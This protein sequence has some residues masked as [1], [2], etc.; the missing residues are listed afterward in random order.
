MALLHEDAEN[1]VFLEELGIGRDGSAGCINTP[2][3]PS[4]GQGGRQLG[5]YNYSGCYDLWSFC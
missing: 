3:V 4:P 1:N 5:G 2:K